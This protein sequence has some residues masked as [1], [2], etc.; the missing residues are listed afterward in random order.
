MKNKWFFRLIVMFV[1]WFIFAS[2]VSYRPVDVTNTQ[3]AQI[4]NVNFHE[5]IPGEKV[6]TMYIKRKGSFINDL[7]KIKGGSW[8][9][10]HK[11]LLVNIEAVIKNG[12]KEMW[13]IEYVD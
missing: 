5:L 1:F 3:V 8:Y 10:A 6:K 12:K 13:R 11:D 9:G 4:S 7:S 2:C